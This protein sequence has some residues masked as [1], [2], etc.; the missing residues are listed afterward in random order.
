M[1]VRI[2]IALP[3]RLR[4]FLPRPPAHTDKQTHTHANESETAEAR[5]ALWRGNANY[6]ALSGTVGV[7]Q[8]TR[9]TNTKLHRFVCLSLLGKKAY[10]RVVTWE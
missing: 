5:F 8:Q 1:A 9:F 3:E 7:S 6:K 10:L 2:G 4:N